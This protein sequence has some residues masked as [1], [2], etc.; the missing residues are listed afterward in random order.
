MASFRK[1]HITKLYAGGFFQAKFTLLFNRFALQYVPSN[2]I[3]N[4]FSL[5]VQVVV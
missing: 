1:S 2:N 4:D 5:R 3:N